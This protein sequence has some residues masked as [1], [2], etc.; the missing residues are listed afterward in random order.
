[1]FIH[2][3]TYN[4]LTIKQDQDKPEQRGRI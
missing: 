1:M 3:D 4:M 2:V